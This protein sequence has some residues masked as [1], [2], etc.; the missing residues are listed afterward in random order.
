M[1]NEFIPTQDIKSSKQLSNNDKVCGNLG[2]KGYQFIKGSRTNTGCEVKP[3]CCNGDDKSNKSNKTDFKH[4]FNHDSK[5]NQN[6]IDEYLEIEFDVNDETP[7]GFGK[8]KGKPH[9][10]ILKGVNENYRKWIVP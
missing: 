9:K 5:I 7:I 3:V 8:L 4:D 1:K 10:E 6:K 2:I